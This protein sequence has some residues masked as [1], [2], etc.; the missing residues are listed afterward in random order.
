MN[1]DGVV[2]VRDVLIAHQILLGQLSLTQDYLNHGDVA[3]L[4]NGVPNSDGLFNLGDMLVI[5]Q[6]ALGTIDF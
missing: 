5:Q 2:D 4:L 6:K 1:V 3:P